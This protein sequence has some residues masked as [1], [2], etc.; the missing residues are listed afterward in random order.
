MKKVILLIVLTMCVALVGT[1]FAIPAG[2]VKV[3]ETKMGNITFS[4]DTHVAKG[5]NC[6]S[7]H[8]STYKMKAGQ[9]IQP[10]PHKV[11]VSCGSCHNGEQ[12]FSVTSACKQCHKK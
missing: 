5:L 12:A 1:A 6:M 8:K 3:V 4:S 2:K 9:L 7:C 10:V 11:G